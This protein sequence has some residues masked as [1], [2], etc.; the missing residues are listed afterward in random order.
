MPTIT[1]GKHKIKYAKN[2]R[3]VNVAWFESGKVQEVQ[4]QMGSEGVDIDDS[5][6]ET[7]RLG[8][9]PNPVND[10]GHVDEEDEDD[11]AA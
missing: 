7:Q 3:V 5:E 9:Q 1:I 6:A 8:F 10:E 2:T 11:D 4:F